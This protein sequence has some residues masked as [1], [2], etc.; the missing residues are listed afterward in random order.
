MFEGELG[1]AKP[2][3]SMQ[4]FRKLNL[5]SDLQ[6]LIDA[7]LASSAK[8]VVVKQPLKSREHQ[9]KVIHCYQGKSVRYDLLSR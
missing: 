3:K 5:K 9:Y 6:I 1:S 7:A 4:V 2:K 8:R